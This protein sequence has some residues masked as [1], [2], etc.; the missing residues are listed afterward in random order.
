[1]I[2]ANQ[3]IST[4]PSSADG[5]SIRLGSLLTTRSRELSNAEGGISPT[6]T[7][8]IRPASLLTTR[9]QEPET[10]HTQSQFNDFSIRPVSLFTT[11]KRESDAGQLPSSVRV[12]LSPDSLFT[13]RKRNLKQDENTLEADLMQENFIGKISSV[14]QCVNTFFIRIVFPLF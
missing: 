11:R 2:S 7:T 14:K 8:L 13:T 5:S 1:M 4:R 3:L 6:G 9:Q 12:S 10:E